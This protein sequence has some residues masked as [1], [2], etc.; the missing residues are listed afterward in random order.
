MRYLALA[1]SYDET[2][3]VEGEIDG[4]TEL[5]LRRL[6]ASG[7][8][9]ILLSRRP[10]ARIAQRL[11][12]DLFA[13]VVA[14][15]GGLLYWPAT[16]R[17]RRLADPLPRSLA[18]HPALRDAEPRTVG[19]VVFTVGGD[20]EV[21]LRTALEGVRPEVEVIADKDLLVAAPPAVTKA[22]G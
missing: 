2:I 15:H 19:E 5:G 14:E 20:Q 21:A 10:V 22:A 7:R 3:A 4:E 16:G 9:L 6:V 11:P 18:E 13:V 12:A 17:S 1:C 8:Q